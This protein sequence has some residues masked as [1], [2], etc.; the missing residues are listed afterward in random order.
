MIK[1]S[2]SVREEGGAFLSNITLPVGCNQ[3]CDVADNAVPIMYLTCGGLILHILK[4]SF[5]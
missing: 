5:H 1:L 2:Y 3:I 4:H